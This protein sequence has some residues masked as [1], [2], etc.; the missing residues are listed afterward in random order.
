MWSIHDSVVKQLLLSEVKKVIF[1]SMHVEAD[2]KYIR[3]YVAMSLTHNLK[4]VAMVWTIT[5]EEINVLMISNTGRSE[6]KCGGV[7]LV[8]GSL[9]ECLV[10]V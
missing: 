10:L 7:A 1:C 3:F 6:F 2:L 5:E 8:S 4:Y 9:E